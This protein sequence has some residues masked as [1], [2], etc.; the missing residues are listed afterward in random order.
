MTRPPAKR[1][2]RPPKPPGEAVRK[3]YRTVPCR[4]HPDEFDAFEQLCASRGTTIYAEVQ[5]LIRKELAR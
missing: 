5:R 2:G 3:L 1:R 4:L